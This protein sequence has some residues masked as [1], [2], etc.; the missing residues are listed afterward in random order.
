MN[1]EKARKCLEDI[2]NMDITARLLNEEF[3][4]TEDKKKKE[5]IAKTVKECTD[6]KTKIIEVILFGLSDARSKEILYKKY[7]LGYTMKEIS[8]KLNYTY[9]YTRILHI[10]ALEQLEEIINQQHNTTTY[11]KTK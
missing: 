3:E 5:K 1:T 2:K 6:K 8:K 9:Q 10:K 4:R 11:N 7:I